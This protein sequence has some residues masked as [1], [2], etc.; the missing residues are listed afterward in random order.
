MM[1]KEIHAIV[2]KEMRLNLSIREYNIVK[3][4]YLDHSTQDEIAAVYGCSRERI[5][6][7]EE[8]AL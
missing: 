2:L 5:R 3:M 8:I 7:I 1:N 4:H 6:Q